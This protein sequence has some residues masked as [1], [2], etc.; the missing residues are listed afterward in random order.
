MTPIMYTSFCTGKNALAVAPESPPSRRDSSRTGVERSGQV[1]LLVYSTKDWI[2]RRKRKQLVR[3]E[4]QNL[5]QGSTSSTRTASSRAPIGRHSSEATTSQVQPCRFCWK[6][7]EQ[8]SS[9]AQNKR[10]TRIGKLKNCLLM[11]NSSLRCS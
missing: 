6:H 8:S 7:L 3:R 2:E 9:P 1:F 11:P 5:K 4:L 10:G